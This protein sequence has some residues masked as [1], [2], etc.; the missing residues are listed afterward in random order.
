MS[1]LEV[2]PFLESILAPQF[3]FCPLIQNFDSVKDK[4]I[5]VLDIAHCAF[6]SQNVDSYKILMVLRRDG[7]FGFVGGRVHHHE[8]VLDGLN[9]EVREETMLE[10][11]LAKINES[12]HLFSYCQ[13]RNDPLSKH[14]FKTLCIDPSV[15]TLRFHFFLKKVESNV[16]YQARLPNY[17]NLPELYGLVTV[18]LRM[19]RMDLGLRT[20]LN[21]QFVATSKFQLL[22]VLH[23]LGLPIQDIGFKPETRINHL[24]ELGLIALCIL[25]WYGCQ[26]ILS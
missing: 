22:I 18:P 16:Y 9:R 19:D 8:K 4:A 15:Q 21:N 11:S 6:Y 24:L 26:I 23:H 1:V 10:P 13:Q 14:V 7:S 5:D 17:D 20:F 2:P 12:D 3:D 25:L